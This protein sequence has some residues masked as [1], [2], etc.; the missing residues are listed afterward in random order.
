M[1]VGDGDLRDVGVVELEDVL[2]AV[3]LR[4]LRVEVRRV[5]VLLRADGP[6]LVGLVGHHHELPRGPALAE[7]LVDLLVGALPRDDVHAVRRVEVLVLLHVVVELQVDLGLDLELLQVGD[8]VLGRLLVGL[9]RHGL[10][11]QT[12]SAP[13]SASA[14]TPGPATFCEDDLALVAVRD[15]DLVDVLGGADGRE[16]LGRDRRLAQ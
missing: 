12:P 1:G 4:V 8:D 3:V 15:A 5:R 13:P 11:G 10:D 14:I 9:R 2:V 7:D 6:H 16:V